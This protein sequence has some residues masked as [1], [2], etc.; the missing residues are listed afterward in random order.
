M[1]TSYYY[2]TAYSSDHGDTWTDI[3]DKEY[4]NA[5][6]CIIN[7]N[8]V[9]I[10]TRGDGIFYQNNFTTNTSDVQNMVIDQSTFIDIRD[11][12]V[13]GR[14]TIVCGGNEA[15]YRKRDGESTWEKCSNG[16][17]TNDF[18]TDIYEHNG[19]LFLAGFAFY[20]SDDSAKSWNMVLPR[21]SGRF[22]TATAIENSVYA[23]N[24]IS[25]VYVSHDNGETWDMGG[26][27]YKNIQTLVS[28]NGI[29]FA[30]SDNGI[31]SSSDSAQSWAPCN[32][33]LFNRNV[34]TLKVKDTTLFAGTYG[35][36]IFALDLKGGMASGVASKR[37]ATNLKDKIILTR[38]GN[39]FVVRSSENIHAV[40]MYNVLGRNIAC[41]ML[42]PETNVH[43]VRLTN[44]NVSP[45]KLLLN[46]T[47][48]GGIITIS[49]PVHRR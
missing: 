30:G 31:F 7:G 19:R 32:E 2:T 5:Y 38:N 3:L 40:D 42:Y 8:S 41:T 24:S 44:I 22:N 45:C 43:V 25:G 13:I 20:V 49:A 35:N 4:I 1:A 29:L 37:Y 14:Y 17:A 34:V 33:G 16:V 47:S 11:F 46:I 6:A 39:Q 23:G 27:T 21:E 26:F 10:G 12:T 15:L 48:S 28:W 18:F 36:G 9:Y